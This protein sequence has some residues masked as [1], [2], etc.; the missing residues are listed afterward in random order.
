MDFGRQFFSRPRGGS[1]I[2]IG[3]MSKAQA[4][5]NRDG[6]IRSRSGDTLIPSDANS[7]QFLTANEAERVRNFEELKYLQGEAEKRRKEVASGNASLES[8]FGTVDDLRNSLQG[9]SDAEIAERLKIASTSADRFKQL[10]GQRA[11][12]TGTSDSNRIREINSDIDR[13]KAGALEAVPEAVNS[14]IQQRVLDERE[15]R[16]QFERAIAGGVN[17]DNVIASFDPS[18]VASLQ[19]SPLNDGSNLNERLFDSFVSQAQDN[20]NYSA[21]VQ[22]NPLFKSF[23]DK[24]PKSGPV[25]NRYNVSPAVQV[26]RQ[27]GSEVRLVSPTDEAP[28]GFGIR[29]TL[30]E[31]LR[32]VALDDLGSL[33]KV[34]DNPL[35]GGQLTSQLDD[36]RSQISEAVS[37]RA[38]L[39]EFGNQ[40]EILHNEFLKTI[41][42]S[43]ADPLQLTQEFKDFIKKREEAQQRIIA[44]RFRPLDEIQLGGIG[45]VS[46]RDDDEDENVFNEDFALDDRAVE[47]TTI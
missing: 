36:L 21:L 28:Q 1:P 31:G 18:V 32:R 8:E 34:T 10:E 16:D 19:L 4:I 38:A 42:G 9:F 20:Q 23:V 46:K 41:G 40:R 26:F 39:D 44:N 5:L 33:R 6:S 13:L 7:R 45:L 43:G 25:A 47:L 17:I 22:S 11:A 27:D 24:I 3:Q 29:E 14:S 35:F 12:F 15:L 30:D 2:D 37:P